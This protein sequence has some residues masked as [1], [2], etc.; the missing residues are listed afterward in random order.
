L[1]K[2]C[3]Q[4]LRNFGKPETPRASSVL[5]VRPVGL[6]GQA[7]AAEVFSTNRYA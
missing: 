7:E 5:R 6:H 1:K 3:R 2:V 4:Q